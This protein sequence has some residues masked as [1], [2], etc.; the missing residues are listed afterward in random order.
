MFVLVH[1]YVDFVSCV[2]FIEISNPHGLT[3]TNQYP[4]SISR[5]SQT[6]ETR[7]QFMV[8]VPAH[9]RKE[10]QEIIIIYEGVVER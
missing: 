10:W 5:C 6:G 2:Q 7:V 8:L 4:L 3:T 1:L 9:N